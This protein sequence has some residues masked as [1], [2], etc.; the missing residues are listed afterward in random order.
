MKRAISHTHCMAMMHG[1]QLVLRWTL[2]RTA[3][4]FDIKMMYYIYMNSGYKDETVARLFV[5]RK[6]LNIE[7][8]SSYWESDRTM[9]VWWFL[10]KSVQQAADETETYVIISMT[11][12]GWLKGTLYP[13]TSMHDRT[14]GFLEEDFTTCSILS[15][16]SAIN[17]RDKK[18]TYI[19]ILWSTPVIALVFM[20]VLVPKI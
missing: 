4:F 14:I 6:Y 15:H 17:I 1:G 10:F 11:S 5:I 20:L 2:Q 3:V 7:R 8:S 18:C 9:G 12:M 19:S 16:I 13:Q